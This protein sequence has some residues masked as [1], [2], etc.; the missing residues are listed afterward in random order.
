MSVLWTKVAVGDDHDVDVNADTFLEV[1]NPLAPLPRSC[2]RVLPNFVSAKE[3][4]TLHAEL[5]ERK[6]QESRWEGFDGPRRRIQGYDFNKDGATSS[7]PSTLLELRRRLRE[8][9][10]LTACNVKVEEYT[11]VQ[12]RMA[13]QAYD[14]TIVSTFASHKRRDPCPCQQQK[15]DCSTTENGHSACTCFMVEIPL[16]MARTTTASDESLVLMQNWNQPESR[17]AICWQLCSPDHYTDVRLHAN[18]AIVKRCDLLTEWRSSRVLTSS[19]AAAE[20]TTVRVLQF[21]SL[22]DIS[23]AAAGRQVENN[24][25]QNDTFGYVPSRQDEIQRTQRLNE[26]MPPLSDLLTII[27]T[28]SPIRSNPSTEVLERAMGTFVMGG[29]EFA[30]QCRKVIVCD[31]FRTQTGDDCQ[32]GDGHNGT[33]HKVSRRHNNLKQAMRNGIV[34]SQQADNYRLFKQNVRT[35]CEQASANGESVFGNAKV[36]ELEERHGYGFALRHVLRNC[37]ETPFVCVVQHDRTFMRPSP[38][39]E[40][41]RAMWLHANIKYVGFSMRSN[42]MYRDIFL[43]KYGSGLQQRQHQEWSD[44]V[45]HVPELCVAATD[46]GPDSASTQAMDVL[47]EKLHQN[48]LAL[49]ETYKGSAQAAIARQASLENDDGPKLHQMSLTPTLFWYDNVHICE[50]KH[51]RDFI[52]YP[53]FKMVTRGGFVEDKLSPILKRTV[54]KMGLKEGHS[55]FGCYLLDDHSGMFFTGHLDGGSY[56]SAEEREELFAAQKG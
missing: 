56:M 18:T 16:V 50:T 14:P 1:S 38:V 10:G 42:L 31:G 39:S 53:P 40:T 6:D 36:V 47:T 43:G 54:E 41:V 2:I 35:L 48:I 29:P 51:Y 28:T 34:T 12:H 15:K 30:F 17:H 8:A 46:Y 25:D 23:T 26:P 19:T 21:Y 37:I 32:G 9:T 22:A 24:V 44:M 3:A 13:G 52:F 55:R 45:L 5:A 33:H 20:S 4:A 27:V 49:A 11:P 7:V